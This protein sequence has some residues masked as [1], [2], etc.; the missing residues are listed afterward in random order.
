MSRIAIEAPRSRPVFTVPVGLS[1]PASKPRELSLFRARQACNEEVA[2][3]KFLFRGTFP[4]PDHGKDLCS[5]CGVVG[6]RV[7]KVSVVFMFFFSF[8][9]ILQIWH[10]FVY[11]YVCRLA[12]MTVSCRGYD[13]QL[14]PP[15]STGSR[16]EPS[17]PQQT[18]VSSWRSSPPVTEPLFLAAMQNKPPLNKPGS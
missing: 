9:K 6:G 4:W 17:E 1:T 3:G 18:D 16:V 5:S 8:R 12:T 7:S 15:R 2:D 13:D 10:V 11:L 14:V